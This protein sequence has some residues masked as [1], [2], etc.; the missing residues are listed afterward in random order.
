MSSPPCASEP[1]GMSSIMLANPPLFVAFL[2][3][4]VLLLTEIVEMIED[5]E[6][7]C[8]ATAVAKAI[9]ASRR[10]KIALRSGDGGLPDNG[11]T[12]KQA[13]KDYDRDR[14]RLCI[15]DDFLSPSCDYAKLLLSH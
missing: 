12:R 14:A 3:V 13:N 11:T 2:L 1:R 4:I 7:Q 15:H 9:L 10:R 8:V 6:K 5:E